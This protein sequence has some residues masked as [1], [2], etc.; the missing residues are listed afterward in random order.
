MTV[1][2]NTPIPGP[3]SQKYKALSK[4]YESRCLTPQAPIVWDHAEGVTVTDVDGNSFI[5]WTSGVLVTNVGHSHPKLAEAIAGQAKRLLNCY[6]F[7]TIERV[8]LAERMVKLAP[9]NLDKAFFATVGSEA[10]DSA[11]RVSK[12][13]TGNFEVISFYGGFHGRTVGSM[14][15]AGKMSSKKRFGPVV[16][17]VIHVPFPDP[18]RNP[19]GSDN[20]DVGAQ[21]LEFLDTAVGAQS[22]GS[23]AAMIVEPYQ[24]AAGFIFPPDGYLGS[25][26]KWCRDNDIV[27]ILDEVQASFGR[28]GKFLALEWEDLRPNLVCIG[29]GIGSG[30]PI[31]CLLAETRIMDSLEEGDMSSTWGGNP[32]CC[33]A[34]HA[35]LDIFEEEKLVENSLKMGEYMKSRLTS[36]K[37]KCRHLGDVRGRGLVIGL[38]IVKDKKTKQRDPETTRHI[39]NECCRRG[40]IIGAV[41]GNV[42]RVAPPLVI[43]KDEADESLDIMEK[44]LTNYFH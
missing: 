26:E 41:S 14:S 29:K 22:T 39:I 13:Y 8:S 43:T 27:F 19:F 36:M 21:C 30:M 33:A 28:T 15:L 40:L 18:Y 4:K 31:S 25:L 23:I 12:R 32:I 34:S 10:V 3:K 11:V 5:D 1:R 17:G 6:D 44:V 7:P 20:G 35:I 9:E 2:V 24:G 37:E 38:D 16:P 42:I